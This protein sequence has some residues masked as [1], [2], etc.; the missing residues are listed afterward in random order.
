MNGFRPPFCVAYILFLRVAFPQAHATYLNLRMLSY[1]N[2]LYASVNCLYDL[3]CNTMLPAVVHTCT[4]LFHYCK[5]MFGRENVIMTKSNLF[6]SELYLSCACSFTGMLPMVVFV[7][8]I[9]PIYTFSYSVIRFSFYNCINS[10]QK[11][12]L[13]NMYDRFSGMITFL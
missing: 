2:V 7:C 3:I 1:A 12:S 4:C 10:E 6:V 5:K 9:V 13:Y 11:Q 8:D